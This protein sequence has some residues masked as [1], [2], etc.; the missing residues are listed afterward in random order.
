MSRENV[1]VVQRL[2]DAFGRDDLQ[3]ALACLD[4]D[5]DWITQPSVNEGTYQ[6]HEGFARFVTDVRDTSDTFELRFDLR[7]LGEHVLA[8]GTI[9]MRG[10]GSGIEIE[11]PVGGIF[12]LREDRVVRWQDFG[13][14]E[15]A[16]E[17]A[18]L[19]EEAMS[20]EN[21][22]VIRRTVEAFNSEGPEAAGR[23]F[24]A[25]DVEFHDPPDS[26]SP[27]VARGREE[28]RKQFT[29]FN[30]TWEKHTTEPQEIRAVGADKVLLVSVE[31]FT[32]RDD[33]ELQAP[34]ASVFTVRDGKVICWEAFWDKGSALEAAGL[35]E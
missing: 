30:E 26:P 24:F 22:D 7:D 8:S 29:A 16:L 28:V 27:R 23:R 12:S 34:S 1:E 35:R 31:H 13:S 11:I 3:G 15:K 19:S 4:P 20:Q 33:I 17:A 32:G 25:D 14:E 9:S 10:I 18:G 2:I 5:V 21:V 6:G